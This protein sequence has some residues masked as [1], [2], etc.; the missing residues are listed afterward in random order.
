MTSRKVAVCPP[1]IRPIAAP[2]AG[3]QIAAG[4][5]DCTTTLPTF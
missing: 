5:G 4:Q 3:R 1:G 2:L